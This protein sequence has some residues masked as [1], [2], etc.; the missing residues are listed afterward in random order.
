MK[1]KPMYLFRWLACL[2]IITKSVHGQDIHFS[3]FNGSLLNANP[4]FTG[5]FD[6]DQRFG[7][8]YRSQ[9]QTV[10]VS[11]ST[12]SAFGDTKLK[13][14]KNSSDVIGVGLLFNNDKA[15]YAN[16]AINQL[17]LSG[18]YQHKL[19]ADSTLL[20]ST[21]LTAG[22]SNLAFNYSKMTFDSQ[23]DGTHYSSSMATGENFAA[24]STSYIDLSAGTLVKYLIRQRAY[25]QYGFTYHHINTPR[26]TYQNN[27]AVKLDPKIYNYLSFQ[28]PVSATVDLLVEVLHQNQGKYNEFLPFAMLKLHLDEKTDQQIGFGFNY[29]TKDAFVPRLFYQF[30]TLNAGIAYDVNTSKFMAATNKQ[31]AFEIYLTYVIRKTVPFVP[32]TRVCPIY[33]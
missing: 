10:P 26:I 12:F 9:W 4:A 14:R 16:Y 29:R 27:T 18:S 5:F 28:Y 25:V 33:M 2:F 13:F 31:G 24:T 21:G 20:W 8:I 11:Y 32:K 23:Y 7:A 30:K 3:Q 22:Y 6:G 17:Y 19:N 15:G 1:R